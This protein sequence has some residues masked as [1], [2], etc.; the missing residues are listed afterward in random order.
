[1]HRQETSDERSDVEIFVEAAI[2]KEMGCAH[3]IS[4][5]RATIHLVRIC[6]KLVDSVIHGRAVS[7]IRAVSPLT[8]EMLA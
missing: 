4:M 8:F 5:L 1:L 3:L 6:K 2:S 7:V